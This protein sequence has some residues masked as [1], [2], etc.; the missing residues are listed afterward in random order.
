MLV[1]LLNAARKV[2][3]A[4]IQ[5]FRRRRLA[6]TSA[7]F[8]SV[9]TNHNNDLH[10]VTWMSIDR[11]QAAAHVLPTRLPTTHSW[12]SHSS[13]VIS[14]PPPSPGYSL[15]PALS[16]EWRWSSISAW[17][18][19]DCFDVY[20]FPEQPSEHLRTPTQRYCLSEGIRSFTFGSNVC[21]YGCDARLHPHPRYSRTIG[22]LVK[23]LI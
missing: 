7:P 14:I 15:H 10:I 13:A 6:A 2:H 5:G 23:E 16:S 20:K 3:E 9:S 4:D 8:G 11:Q 1:P 22:S 12:S 21:S 19:S 18:L 17:L